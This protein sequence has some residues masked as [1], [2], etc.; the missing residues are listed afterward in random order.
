[1]A[2]LFSFSLSIGLFTELELILSDM[3]VTYFSSS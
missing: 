3:G 2:F 1:M